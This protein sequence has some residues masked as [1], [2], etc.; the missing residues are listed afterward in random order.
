MLRFDKKQNSV[1]YPSI[2]K[3]INFKKRVDN[4]TGGK[5]GENSLSNVKVDF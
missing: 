4:V 2:K 1:K 3:L 5:P